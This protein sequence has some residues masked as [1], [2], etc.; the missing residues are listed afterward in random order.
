MHRLL[1]LYGEP[2][3]P[4][5][6]RKY[7][8]ETHYPLASKIPGALSSSYSFDVKGLD[9]GEKA[10]YFGVYEASFASEEAMF[11]ALSSEFGKTVQADVPNYATGGVTLL[12]FAVT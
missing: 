8:V 11:Q 3:D 12:H 7:Y 5:H 4:A 9:G 6:F 10:P 1:V 2:K